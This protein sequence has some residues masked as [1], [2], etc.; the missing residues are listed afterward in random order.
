MGLTLNSCSSAQH[1]HSATMGLTMIT[2]RLINAAIANSTSKT[3]T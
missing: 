3:G 2:V 1:K